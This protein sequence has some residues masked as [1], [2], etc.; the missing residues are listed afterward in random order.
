MLD[1]ELKMRG[2]SSFEFTILM[3][4]G[5]LLMLM[6]IIIGAGYSKDAVENSRQQALLDLGY[7]IQD[8]L[9]LATNVQEGYEHDIDLPSTLGKFHY[10]IDT[11]ET[12]LQLSS[13]PQVYSFRIP[14]TTGSFAHGLNTIRYDGDLSVIS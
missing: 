10:E 2:Q 1:R 4:F 12:R 8:E 7:T 13:G 6:L 9:I 3:A 14:N 5:M 11:F